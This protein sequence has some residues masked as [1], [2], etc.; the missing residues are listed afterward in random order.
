MLSTPSILDHT[1]SP[2]DTY[3]LSGYTANPPGLDFGDHALDSMDWLDI[4]MGGASNEIAGLAPLGPL[5]PHTPPSVFSADFLDS[6]DLQ[7]H[8]DSCL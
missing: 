7:L 5:G 3:E 6:S 8:W 2:M 1:S 4:T